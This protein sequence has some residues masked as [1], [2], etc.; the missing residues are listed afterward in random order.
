MSFERKTNAQ[1]TVGTLSD[2]PWIADLESLIYLEGGAAMSAENFTEAE[3]PDGVPSGTLVHSF[4]GELLPGGSNNHPTGLTR[5][6]WNPKQRGVGSTP[7]MAV[8][9]GGVI[10]VDKLPIMPAP[11]ALPATFVQQNDSG[12]VLVPTIQ[13]E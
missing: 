9:V 6:A 7:G 1:T 4:A 2:A 5:Y 13:E 11:D 10:H 12:K 3:Y 8:V